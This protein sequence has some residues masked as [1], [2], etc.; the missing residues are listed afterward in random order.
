MTRSDAPGVLRCSQLIVGLVCGLVL[1]TGWSFAA[2]TDT[3]SVTGS[4]LVEHI[5]GDSATDLAQITITFDRES[6]AFGSSGCNRFRGPFKRDGETIGIGPLAATKK[7]CAAVLM[8][9]EKKFFS[10]DQ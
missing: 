8:A 4:W 10:A 1:Q 5:Q 2:N 3:A 7:M 6:H 9:R